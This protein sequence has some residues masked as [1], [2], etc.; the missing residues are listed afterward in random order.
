SLHW[1]SGISI[2]HQQAGHVVLIVIQA[3][4]LLHFHIHSLQVSRHQDIHPGLY[5]F[6]SELPFTD[7]DSLAG[8]LDLLTRG[9]AQ[10][11][12]R[13]YGCAHGTLADA[14]AVVTHVALHHLVDFGLIFGNAERAGEDAIHAA[15]TPGLER[16]LHHSVRSFLDG[17]RGTNLGA[18]GFV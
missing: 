10:R 11:S 15:D 17:I 12:G 9:K 6:S 5:N 13:A 16:A 14:G 7:G 2:P 8:T 1:S 4:Q 18:D 3:G